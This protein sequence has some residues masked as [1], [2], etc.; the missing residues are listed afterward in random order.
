MLEKLDL[1]YTEWIEETRRKVA[2]GIAQLERGDRL[3][4]E[5][6]I[7]GIIDKFREAKGIVK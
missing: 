7:E 1:E 3:D 5:L 2:I 6:V 4:A